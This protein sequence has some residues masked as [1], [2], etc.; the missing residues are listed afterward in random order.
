MD[1]LGA[2]VNTDGQYQ[3][4]S[5]QALFHIF[6]ANENDRHN[7]IIQIYFP[8]RIVVKKIKENLIN[9]SW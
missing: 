5:F 7:L 3:V 4:C 2:S 1:C 9:Y 6:S 8:P